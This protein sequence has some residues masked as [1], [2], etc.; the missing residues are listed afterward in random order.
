MNRILELLVRVRDEAG[1]S[2][3]E[4]IEALYANVAGLAEGTQIFAKVFPDLDRGARMNVLDIIDVLCQAVGATRDLIRRCVEGS[5]ESLAAV[6]AGAAWRIGADPVATTARLVCSL[7][8]GPE[9]ARFA[10][11]GLQAMGREARGAS[12]HLEELLDATEVPSA[13]LAFTLWKISDSPERAMRALNLLL[14]SG[15]REAQLEAIGLLWMMG[16]DAAGAMDTLERLC[17]RCQ[18]NADALRE[19]AEALLGQL[20][21]RGRCE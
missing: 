2:R 1:E 14:D 7:D 17:S 16:R 11:I 8:S 10:L 6:A 21:A 4:A 18:P 15:E 19:K 20:K 13:R 5:D 9:S 3:Q 12:A